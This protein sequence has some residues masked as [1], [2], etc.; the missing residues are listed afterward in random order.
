MT[1]MN[2]I[3]AK[4]C[5]VAHTTRHLFTLSTFCL[6]LPACTAAVCKL[7]YMVVTGYTPKS[8]VTNSGQ[9][10]EMHILE[11]IRLQLRE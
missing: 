4:A 7:H 3:T 2:T 5:R 8:I 11:A 9:R 6:L 1:A 10:A